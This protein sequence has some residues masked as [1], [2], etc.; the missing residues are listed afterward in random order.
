M[1]T[2]LN[3][4]IESSICLALAILFYKLVLARLTHFE[5]NRLAILSFLVAG[6]SIPLFSFDLSVASR[7]VSETLSMPMVT[8]GENVSAAVTTTVS[9]TSYI[10]FLLQSIYILGL[11]Y[12]LTQLGLG[13][14][15][16]WLMA[17][18][19][20][21]SQFMGFTVITDSS[22]QPSSFFRYIFLPSFDPT[23]ENDRQIFLHESVHVRRSHTID[24]LFIQLVKVVF[25]FNPLIYI[26][27]TMIR[28]VHKFEADGTVSQTFS[29]RHYSLL[30]LD[31]LAKDSGLVVSHPF[32]QFQTKKRIVMM[33]QPKSVN[34]EKLRFLLLLPLI[35]IMFFAF[36]CNLTSEE[37]LEGP[38]QMGEKAVSMGPSDLLA[39]ARILGADGN[40]I[41][42]V[43]EQ[44][45]NPPG[46]MAG[47]N[48]YLSKNLIYPSEAKEVGIEGTVI[49]VFVVQSDGSISDVDILRS[50]GA[51]CD[52]EAIRVVENAPNW[53]PGKQRDRLVNTRM[54]LPIR[55]KLNKS[56]EIAN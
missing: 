1:N 8:V 17:R 3:Y 13:L 45:P 43:V 22:F 34:S 39:S 44:Q 9:S 19:G 40:E 6:L 18:V 4:F 46:G 41:F 11:L 7:E 54:R 10:P 16:V 15:R 28:E 30:L 35:G 36:S 49:V 50:V 23:N 5:W 38:S 53:Q 47:W 12:F 2:F 32:N 26:F 37:E 51:G 27:E 56:V 25:W 20:E 52:E 55:F 48:E 21:R 33:N 14:Y 24:L 42:D 31:Q 29:T